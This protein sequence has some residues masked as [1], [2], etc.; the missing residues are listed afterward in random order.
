MSTIW[1][2]A[3]PVR[4]DTETYVHMPLD[5]RVLTIAAQRDDLCLWAIVEPNTR[6]ERRYFCVRGTGHTLGD[7]GEYVGT[8]HMANGLVWHVFEAAS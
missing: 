8:A 7:V 3:I 1:K 4:I 5:A 6:C 2:F